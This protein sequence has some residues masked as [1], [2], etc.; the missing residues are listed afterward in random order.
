MSQGQYQTQ[1][2]QYDPE[3]YS[4]PYKGQIEESNSWD[5]NT[6][7]DNVE[8]QP[9][10]E[11]ANH[12]RWQSNDVS[13]MVTIRSGPSQGQTLN[14]TRKNLWSSFPRTISFRPKG[15]IRPKN[16]NS[17]GNKK[18]MFSNERTLVHWM[19]AAML[20]GSL[21]MTLL[22][23]GENNITPY[24]GLALLM[25]CLICLI[26]SSTTFHVRME[27]LGMRRDDVKYY[28]RYAPTVFTLLIMAT[29]LFNAIGKSLVQLND[30]NSKPDRKMSHQ[31]DI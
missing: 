8:S 13:S 28:D 18:A 9:V 21:S 5:G 25:V 11:P 26:Y 15:I 17:M 30:V 10:K 22:S 27:W 31:M 3:P 4:L 1:G 19:K 24:V 14:K 16:A 29:F 6:Q 12:N 2:G 7:V 20:L 23:F